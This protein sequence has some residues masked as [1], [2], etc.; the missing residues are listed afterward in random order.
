MERVGP[1]G[2]GSEAPRMDR[3][4]DVPE[5]R[6][7]QTQ[8]AIETLEDR[9]ALEGQA[10]RLARRVDEDPVVRGAEWREARLLASIELSRAHVDLDRHRARR[11]LLRVCSRGV[12]D[13]ECG[14]AEEEPVVTTQQAHA[15]I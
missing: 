12:S 1:A 15:V 14:R 5:L 3:R 13:T 9:G 2:A 6:R 10:R 11:E 8:R 4:Y 7:R